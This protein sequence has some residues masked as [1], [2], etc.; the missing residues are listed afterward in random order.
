MFERILPLSW[1][2]ATEGKDT[3]FSAEQARS[4]PNVRYLPCQDC[5]CFVS[6]L[7]KL[8]TRKACYKD[9]LYLRRSHTKQTQQNIAKD[10]RTKLVGKYQGS[11]SSHVTSEQSFSIPH[12]QAH[13]K[14]A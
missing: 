6:H 4:K 5:I 13:P 7:T 9:Q 3:S 2:G 10:E 1:A 14:Q 8:S 11:D 12:R